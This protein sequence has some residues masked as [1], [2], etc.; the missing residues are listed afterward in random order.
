MG[1]MDEIDEH[2]NESRPTKQTGRTERVIRSELC[3]QRLQPR[4]LSA[5]R[6][7]A[8]VRSRA[9]AIA[10]GVAVGIALGMASAFPAA[11][12]KLSLQADRGPHYAGEPVEIT[13]TADGFAED[14]QPKIEIAGPSD[15]KLSYLGVSPSVQSS[16]SIVNGKMTRTRLIRFI[17]RYRF[18]SPEPGRFRLGPFVVTQGTSRAQSGP[19]QI[20]L[21]DLPRSDR[22]RLELR[23]PPGPVFVGQKVPVT[24]E[25][26]IERGLQDN[27]QNYVLSVPLFDDERLRFLEDPAST[28]DGGADLQIHSAA[29]RVKVRAQARDEIQ[30]G[31]RYL[32]LS[33][34]RTMMP[35][36]GG[37]ISAAAPSIIISE[38]TRW[39]RDLFGGRQAAAI[40]KLKATGSAVEIEV[41]GVPAEGRPAGFA[42]A[43]GRGFTL[44]VTADRTVVQVGEP[45]VLTFTLRGDGD[46]TTAALPP[47][48]AEGLLPPELFR[49]PDE[50]PTGTVEDGAKRFNAV[51]R[52]LDDSVREVPALGYSWFDAGTRRFQT[53]QTRPIAL[54]VRAAE[55]IGAGDVQSLAADAGSSGDSFDGALPQGR[56]GG[57][58]AP[59][60]RS[61]ALTGADLG[62]ERDPERLLRNDLSSRGG[63]AAAVALHG[64]GLA[65][66]AAAGIDRRR[67]DEDPE[68]RGRRGALAAARADVAAALQ[69]GEREAARALGRALR[70]MHALVPDFHDTELDAVL[71]DCDALSYA[72]DGKA[73][74]ASLPEALGERARRVADA[75]QEAGP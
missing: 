32:V 40:R 75:M 44:E 42:G 48:D 49:V 28:S 57:G 5:Q 29:G 69:L 39:K 23:V 19:A 18:Q 6:P 21:L 15:S 43:I 4:S 41:A 38:A 1:R 24:L 47:L 66:I 2:E 50:P 70:A 36:E 59:R 11:A 60:A 14:P 27:L 8:A 37:R 20:E 62:V 64:L 45:V 22:A 61:L 30:S 73:A 72:P 71:G 74:A 26:W 68:Q 58:A 65:L 13:V 33:V 34:T 46:L 25:L 54:S 52:V 7:R 9:L 51:V 3:R 63:W 55:V 16:I 31:K 56:D 10:L 53:T 35:R 12:Q 67:R 17:Y